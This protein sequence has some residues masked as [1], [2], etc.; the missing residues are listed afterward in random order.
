MSGTE[1]NEAA[2]VE[3]TV[4][5]VSN[6]EK[7]VLE[8]TVAKKEDPSDV[9]ETLTLNRVYGI[10][11]S[12]VCHFDRWAQLNDR[13]RY[14]DSDI[15]IASY[16]KCGTTWSEQC[17]LLLANGANPD[18]LDPQHKNSYDSDTR[19]GKIWIETMVEQDPA[20]QQTMGKEGRPIPWDEFDAAPSPRVL[21]THAQLCQLLGVA[22]TM[23]ATSPPPPVERAI[24][25]LDTLPPGCKVLV[26]ARNPLDACVSCYYHPKN[27]P[28][29]RGWPFDAFAEVYLQG[30][31]AFGSYFDWTRDWYA[32]AQARPDRII[33]V[34][35]EAMKL[36]SLPTTQRLAE[37]LR[38]LPSDAA[39][40][41]AFLR[42]VVHH[43]SFEEMKRQVET[44]EGGD[45]LQHLR[46]GRVGDWR[47]HFSPAMAAKMVA[48]TRARL[49]TELAER[50]LSYAGVGPL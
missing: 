33:W 18:V 13:V 26:V 7:N 21:K 40:H 12:R 11:S 37:F 42:R 39:Q 2:T 43:A 8:V 20:V 50:L 14:R 35:F 3:Y 48:Q 28:A 25:A 6:D 47:S 4:T 1:G 31:V 45:T 10:P 29:K 23:P 24:A 49:P 34:E 30:H 38:L 44:K 9:I 46:G 32:A 36:E 16:P 19:T 5:A 27:S 17:V 41:D 22:P 15:I